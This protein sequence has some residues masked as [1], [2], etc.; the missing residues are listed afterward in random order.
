V[1]AER[2]LERRIVTVLF[3]DLVGFTSLSEA[4]DPEDVVAVQDAYFAAVHETVTRYGGTLEKFIGDAAVAV[5]GVPRVRDDDAAHAVRAAL[6]LT[7]AVDQL[8]ARLGLAAG[9]LR[10]RVGVNTGEVVY[11]QASAERGPVTGDTV[12]VAARLQAA[13]P[14]GAVLIGEATALAVE[15]TVELEAAGPLELKGKAEATRAWR[16]LAERTEPS[17]ERAMGG[18]RAPMLGRKRELERLERALAELQAGAA[19]TVAV[20]APPGVGKTRLVDELARAAASDAMVCRARLRPDVLAPY[21]G[22]AQLLAAALV[23]AGLAADS[24]TALAAE[25][26]LTDRL[27]E[28]GTDPGRTRVVAESVVAVLF[29]AAADGQAEPA[30]RDAVFAAW[31]DAFDALGTSGR[32]LWIVEDA[33]WAGGDLLAFLLAAG[34]PPARSPRLVV[35]TGRPALRERFDLD[36]ALE[37]PPL[38]PR[39]TA[40]LIRKLVGGA[41]PAELVGRIAQASDGN[42]LFV[43]E[44]LRT[45]A[46]S[47]LLVAEGDR[48]QLTADPAEVSVP[49]TVQTIYA[50]QLDDLPPPARL[51]ARRASVPGRRF[52]AAALEALGVDDA[53]E[54]LEVLTRRALIGGPD[55]DAVFGS[56]YT[57]RHALL[58]DAGY[59]SL[60]RAER[61][62]LHVRLARWLEA[63]A[64]ERRG[65]IAELIGRHYAAAAESAPRLAAEVAP[66]LSRA[67]AAHAAAGWLELGADTA[68]ELGAHETAR[69]LLTRALELT[70]EEAV[71]DAARRRRRLG[72]AI[73]QSA[74]MDEA[75]GEL[76][77]ARELARTVLQ[78]TEGDEHAAGRA[79]YAAAT[80]SLGWVYN[81]QVRFDDAAELARKA[82]EELGEGQ[83]VETARLLLLRGTAVGY[84]TDEIDG[85][86]ADVRR[87]AAIARTTHAP[88]VELD[89]VALHTR[90]ETDLGSATVADLR[91]V[92]RLALR[93][94]RWATAAAAART[95]AIMLFDGDPLAAAD[96]LAR[97]DELCRARGLLEELAWT[98]YARTELGLLTGDW[99]VALAAGL[100]AVD[101]AERNA[102]R[103]AGIRSWYAILPIA[104]AR[105][106][107]EVLRRA[108]A[109]S[110]RFRPHF[111]TVPAP[112]ARVM[113]TAADL[114]F[115]ALGWPR[116]AIYEPDDDAAV[117]AFDDA[118][119]LPSF[120]DAADAVI[121]A[122][123]ADGA[124]ERVR[125][126]LAVAAAAVERAPAR[127]VTWPA[128]MTLLR[129]R[130]GATLGDPVDVGALRPAIDALRSVPAPAWLARGFRQL[131]ALGAATV[132]EVAEADAIDRRLGIA[133]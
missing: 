63:V 117:P 116:T 64:G 108:H 8:G 43:E 61:A 14:P 26:L 37:L 25:R 44:L 106:D 107:E 58:R 47:G 31:L 12:N 128:V 105:R 84:G 83:D 103:R 1:A 78:S 6:A 13:A 9:E 96:A 86:L 70:E 16:A 7:S 50:A 94:G 52:P 4:L 119:Q 131:E 111:P 2:A 120:C 130:L 109:F 82:L 126:A 39:T 36:D 28:A 87:A 68:L 32:V 67:E 73:A 132:E 121:G 62:A 118:G 18:L 60:A 51:T 42:P 123:L 34:S 80:A 129:A 95:E 49:T 104:A 89:A 85:P 76:E 125:A 93:R 17:R 112:W 100:R 115:A 45:W 77:R 72:E 81:Q 71:L 10:L 24:L 54:G 75:A 110:S 35:V 55:A 40:T 53:A 114:R 5:F 102:Y 3:C 122:W 46:S 79:E 11:G 27:S 98:D 101:L 38:S 22:V 41:V 74:D 113:S 59:A 29:P 57:F 91:E 99:D 30:N 133:R 20:L 97:A 127:P 23:A 19:H 56:T 21:D 33:H 48:W 124:Y 92:E 88:D 15:D 90:W 69:T 66:Q 65:Q